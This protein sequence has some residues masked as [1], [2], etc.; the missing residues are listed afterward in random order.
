MTYTFEC[1]HCQQRYDQQ[2]TLAQFERVK[3]HAL[4]G[5][6]AMEGRAESLRV[7]IHP[8][9]FKLCGAAR[10]EMVMRELEHG[11]C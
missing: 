4:C 6:C 1:P 7:V 10:T 3:Q 8:T 11:A 5:Y 9:P 2:M